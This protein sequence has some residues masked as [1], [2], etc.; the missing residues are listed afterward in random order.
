MYALMEYICILYATNSDFLIE[1]N[2]VFTYKYYNIML[3][4]NGEA[5]QYNS[6]TRILLLFAGDDCIYETRHTRV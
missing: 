4:Y 5:I 2:T 6:V 3:M 1:L